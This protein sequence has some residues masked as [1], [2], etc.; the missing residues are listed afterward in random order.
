M[1]ATLLLMIKLIKKRNINLG[2]L[3][4]ELPKRSNKKKKKRGKKNQK[5]QKK[6]KSELKKSINENKKRFL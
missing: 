1:H 4:E 3:Q 5:N 6:R 2:I